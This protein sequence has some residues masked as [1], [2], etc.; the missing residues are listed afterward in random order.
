M[1]TF[2]HY[3]SRLIL[4][5]FALLSLSMLAS[6]H[7]PYSWTWYSGPLSLFI[8]VFAFAHI[9][10]ALC[11]LLKQNYRRVALFLVLLFT[12]YPYSQRMFNR[13]EM[14]Q[15]EKADLS[16]M[17]ANLAL[18]N[19]GYRSKGL[20]DSNFAQ[21]QKIIKEHQP[22]LL[23]FQEFYEKKDGNQL[24]FSKALKSMGYTHSLHSLQKLTGYGKMTILGGTAI[25]SKTLPLRL[26]SKKILAP[27]TNNCQ[28]I[29]EADWKGQKLFISNVH[30]QSFNMDAIRS[31]TSQTP[32]STF[33]KKAYKE[34][35]R[36]SKTLLDTLSK[37]NSGI[38]AG[39]FNASSTSYIYTLFSKK[40][41]NAFESGGTGFACSWPSQWPLV[42]IDHV[43]T[44]R[45]WQALSEKSIDLPFSD[46]RALLVHLRKKSN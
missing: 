27:N 46:H 17:T 15:N 39:D 12:A 34:R 33:L 22:D 14:A 45:D 28:I 29:S 30:L 32:T 41:E 43:F 24:Q 20:A 4:G 9:L 26:V 44:T 31:D 18:L 13:A 40:L 5:L 2:L 35:E 25:F 36:Q 38:L 23:F 21:L 7:I 1:G 10:L 8:P 3:L 6:P 11:S 19:Y 37:W 16:I 42:K